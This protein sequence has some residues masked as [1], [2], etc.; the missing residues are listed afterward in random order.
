[1]HTEFDSFK[2]ISC[3]E[4]MHFN[5]QI[6]NSHSTWSLQ[7]LSQNVILYELKSFSVRNAAYSAAY[8]H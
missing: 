4:L 7:M 3:F 1:M 5:E 6:Q 8:F 2:Q